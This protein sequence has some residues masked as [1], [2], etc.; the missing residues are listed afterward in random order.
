MMKQS[1]TVC[2]IYIVCYL[3]QLMYRYDNPYTFLSGKGVVSPV[4]KVA[5]C[6]MFFPVWGIGIWMYDKNW[7]RADISVYRY[8]SILKWWNKTGEGLT[9]FILSAYLLL[10]L[11]IAAAFPAALPYGKVQILG[12]LVLHAWGL[13]LTG[14][15]LSFFIRDIVYVGAVLI[16]IELSIGADMNA[17]HWH[18]FMIPME[19][20]LFVSLFFLFPN[21]RK[22]LLIRKLA[23]EKN[24]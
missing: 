5:W 24:D 23:Y 11:V 1:Y 15:L 13:L 18:G 2:V 20:M 4:D 12:Q 3:G 9:V 14:L 8:H 21:S 22:G 16:L 10:C 7:K 17:A 19:I 6:M